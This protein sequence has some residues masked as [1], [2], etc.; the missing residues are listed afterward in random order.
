MRNT[1]GKRPQGLHFLRTVQ[2][3]LELK[4]LRFR[5]PALRY[6]TVDSA[7]AIYVSLSI[8][9]RHGARLENHPSP[10]F[11]QVDMLKPGK[12]LPGFTKPFTNLLNPSASSGGMKSKGLFHNTSSG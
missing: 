10:V 2:S 11:A 5:I 3:L 8:K 1:A 7:I 4:A 6:V 9:D 12:R